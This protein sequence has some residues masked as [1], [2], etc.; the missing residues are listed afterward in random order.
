MKFELVSTK[1]NREG[2]FKLQMLDVEQFATPILG[3]KPEV[4]EEFT[5]ATSWP[6]RKE[7]LAATKDDY[8]NGT[9][10]AYGV[11]RRVS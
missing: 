5:L 6:T 10:E 3:H 11:F 4:G 8:E 2:E 1:A 9:S 7:G